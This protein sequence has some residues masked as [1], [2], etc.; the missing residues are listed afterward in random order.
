MKFLSNFNIL[1]KF[2]CINLVLF[3]LKLLFLF[4]VDVRNFKQSNFRFEKQ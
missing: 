2:E 4:D 1:L 3:L